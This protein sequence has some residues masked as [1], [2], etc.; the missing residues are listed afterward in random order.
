M[1]IEANTILDVEVDV[2]EVLRK[3]RDKHFREDIFYD[4][5][6]K[7]LVTENSDYCGHCTTYKTYSTDKEEI[8]FFNALDTCIKYIKKYGWKFKIL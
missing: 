3:I 7:T 6:T 5:K 4:K 1:K 8:D 2:L